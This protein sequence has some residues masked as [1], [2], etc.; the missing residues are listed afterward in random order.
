MLFRSVA[1]RGRLIYIKASVTG[2]EPVD[3]LEYKARF[4]VFPHESTGDQS[5]DESQFE[6][7]RTL[8]LHIAGLTMSPWPADATGFTGSENARAFDA[9]AGQIDARQSPAEVTH[10]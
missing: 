4:P 10:G 7:Y 8:G 5:F 2:D 3:V 1:A 9:A 6:S